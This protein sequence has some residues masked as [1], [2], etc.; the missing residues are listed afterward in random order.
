MCSMCKTHMGTT[1]LRRAPEFLLAAPAKSAGVIGDD[2][3]E[4]R[5]LHVT[6]VW[7]AQREGVLK[8]ITKWITQ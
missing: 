8:I 6:G 3:R 7:Q 1:E 2:K 5:D 4:L